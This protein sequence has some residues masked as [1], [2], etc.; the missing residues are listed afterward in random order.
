[1]LDKYRLPVT[2]QGVVIPKAWFGDATEVALRE[3][4][5]EIKV[6]PLTSN[7]TSATTE[8]FAPDDP[9]WDLGKHPVKLGVDDAAQ[10]HDRYIYGDPHRVSE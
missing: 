3:V 9:I 7:E 1:M 2:D 6:T 4:D 10:N 8:A 5:G